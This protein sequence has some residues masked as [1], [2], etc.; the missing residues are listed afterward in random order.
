MSDYEF[1]KRICSLFEQYG[2]GPEENLC[3][4]AR[5]TSAFSK[6]PPKRRE[7]PPDAPQEHCAPF[8]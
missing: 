5:V 2:E 6:Q 4:L 3:V 1:L 7:N 8:E